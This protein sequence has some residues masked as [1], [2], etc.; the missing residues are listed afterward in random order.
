MPAQLGP[1]QNMSC[2]LT[3]SSGVRHPSIMK[4][5]AE[6]VQHVPLLHHPL[7]TA[8]STLSR[9]DSNNYAGGLLCA[10]EL[11]CIGVFLYCSASATQV[12]RDDRTTCTQLKSDKALNWNFVDRHIGH[13]P[14][15]YQGT[16]I[17]S[18]AANQN[19]GPGLQDSL[20]EQ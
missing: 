17:R 20:P 12:N 10:G 2:H 4:K 8:T 18:I 15:S 1:V 14:H 5:A 3:Q 7:V 19:T 9:K 16:E 6:C 13:F 11:A